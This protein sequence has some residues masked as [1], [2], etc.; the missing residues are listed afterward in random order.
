MHTSVD[1]EK[2]PNVAQHTGTVLDL[3]LYARYFQSEMPTDVPIRLKEMAGKSTLTTLIIACVCKVA[4][5]VSKQARCVFPPSPS[6]G[7]HGYCLNTPPPTTRL[8]NLM[9]KIKL[10]KRF[11][12]SVCCSRHYKRPAELAGGEK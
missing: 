1:L 3:H 9:Q 8:F 2:V 5:K 10:Q 4:G 12:C 11:L 6:S 7:S